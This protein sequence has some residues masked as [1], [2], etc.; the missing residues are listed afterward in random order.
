[1]DSTAIILEPSIEDPMSVPAASQRHTHLKFGAMTSAYCLGVFNDSFF[2]QACM[3]IAVGLGFAALQGVIMFVFILPYLVAAAPAGWCADR[4]SKRR[5]V[6]ATKALELL[7]MLF[8]ALGIVLVS[9]PLVLAMAFTMGLQSCLF[10]PAMNGSV[11]ELYSSA[12]VTV[13]NSVLKAAMIAAVLLGTA[14][15]G[16]ALE[17]GG[18]LVRPYLGGSLEVASRFVIA[19]VVVTVALLGLVASLATPARPAAAPT[20]PFPWAGPAETIRELQSLTRDQ[21]LFVAA[22]L[23]TFVWSI[24]ALQAMLINPLGKVEFGWGDTATSGLLAVEMIGVAVGGGLAGAFVRGESWKRLLVPCLVAMAGLLGSLA[25]LWLLPDGV[26]YSVALAL[27]FGSGVVGG[28]VLIPC[29]AF[30]QVR[31]RAEHRGAVL[32]AYGFL[33]GVGVASASL[34]AIVLN[35]LFPPTIGFGITGIF[36]LGLALLVGRALRRGAKQ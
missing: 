4:F 19:A 35:G 29:E 32:G 31:P 16:V 17:S 9:W 21:L 24:G 14:L 12:Q 15:A 23:G 33:F 34:I 36:T 27:L 28:L 8:G 10:S 1:M 20:A 11:P 18:A 22:L 5:V 13:A 7:A 25:G 26:R 3:L 2:K 30:V 6:I